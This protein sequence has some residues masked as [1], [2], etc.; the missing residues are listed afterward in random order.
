[1][2]ALK[3]Q[4]PSLFRM[5][6]IRE[7]RMRGGKEEEKEEEAETQKAGL[8]QSLIWKPRRGV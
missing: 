4:Q 6:S 5:C 3:A 1:M 2:Y 7:M 8:N